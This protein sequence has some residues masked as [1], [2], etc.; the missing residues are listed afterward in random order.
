MPHSSDILQT[1]YLIGTYMDREVWVYFGEEK[2][3]EQKANNF[4]E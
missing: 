4:W 2:K 3:M 1:E